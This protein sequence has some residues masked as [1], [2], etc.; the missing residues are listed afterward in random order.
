MKVTDE[1][2]SA[3]LLDAHFRCLGHQ[4]VRCRLNSDDPPDIICEVDGKEWGIEVTRVDQREVQF[5]VI[6][7]RARIDRPLMDF[8]KQLGQEM[9]QSRRRSYLLILNGPPNN[10]WNEW[11]ALVRS[12]VIGF[13]ESDR[14]GSCDFPG[15]SVTACE[16]GDR[17]VCSVGLRDDATNSNGG[18]TSD[19]AFNIEDMLRHA[20]NEKAGKL[21][22]SGNFDKLGL[23]L[24]NQ[25]FFGDDISETEA[26]T[27]RIVHEKESYGIIDAIFYVHDENLFAIYDKSKIEDA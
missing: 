19:I 4:N 26:T 27:R 8:G 2:Y 5:G 14:C 9:K 16:E 17:W 20:I 11:K 22:G 6:K 24:L 23:L 1:E 7:S 21:G 12:A 10:K 3:L 15:G 13:V 25:Y 18:L